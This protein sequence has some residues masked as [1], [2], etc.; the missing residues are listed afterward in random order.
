[1]AKGWTATRLMPRYLAASV[2][3]YF[4]AMLLYITTLF[5]LP[6]VTLW[7]SGLKVLNFIILF[8]RYRLG[9]PVVYE[10]KDSPSIVMLTCAGPML[11][12]PTSRFDRNLCASL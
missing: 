1:V 6:A 12:I 3:V 4:L 5:R 8:S 9:N 10:D 2:M 7:H 11:G